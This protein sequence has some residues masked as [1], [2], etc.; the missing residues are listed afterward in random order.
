MAV[1]PN[2]QSVKNAAT[3]TGALVSFDAG[4]SVKGR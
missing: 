4:K 1:T 2:T 3:T